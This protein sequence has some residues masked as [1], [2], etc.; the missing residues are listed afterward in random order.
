[1]SDVVDRK[2]NGN[3]TGANFYISNM[4]SHLIEKKM[5]IKTSDTRN[6]SNSW[7]KKMWRGHSLFELNN[8][9]ITVVKVFLHKK[10]FF[11]EF[12]NRE[13]I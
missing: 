2:R 11:T 4:R 6:S 7:S 9:V 10:S 1:M 3:S 12:Y 13:P 8:C 5:I